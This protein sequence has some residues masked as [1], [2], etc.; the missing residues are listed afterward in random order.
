LEGLATPSTVD[1][2]MGHRGVVLMVMRHTQRRR[3]HGDGDRN[4]VGAAAVRERARGHRHDHADEAEMG[5]RRC[6]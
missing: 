3:H 5:R 6:W 1:E 2:A 4:L